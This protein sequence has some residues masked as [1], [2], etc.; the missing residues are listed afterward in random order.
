MAKVLTSI[1]GYMEAAFKSPEE[2]FADAYDCLADQDFDTIV[3]TGVSGDLIVPVLAREIGCLFAI[4]R[5]R[6]ADSHTHSE[7]EGNIGE[8]WVFVDDLIDSGATLDKVKK[9]VKHV[10]RATENW[11]DSINPAHPTEFVGTYLYHRREWYPSDHL[12]YTD[13]R[14]RNCY[15]AKC[16]PVGAQKKHDTEKALR[17]EDSFDSYQREYDFE[18]YIRD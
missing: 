17:R 14:G 16:D 3:G 9:S 6:P 1:T 8:R 5:K 10:C 7:L 12:T 18:F 4:V 13:N 15:C 11:D 2:I